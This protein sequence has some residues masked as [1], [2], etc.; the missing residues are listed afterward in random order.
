MITA[1]LWTVVNTATLTE[2]WTLVVVDLKCH[3]TLS[4][5]V[6]KWIV[7]NSCTTTDNFSWHWNQ[8]SSRTVSHIQKTT[9]S[10]HCLIPT[11]SGWNRFSSVSSWHFYPRSLKTHLTHTHLWNFFGSMYWGSWLLFLSTLRWRL[12]C[13]SEELR[14]SCNKAR[15]Q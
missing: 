13:F 9:C 2:G 3:R 15:F 8:A 12:S 1:G 4:S 6:T 10:A 7:H 14:A 5:S 11:R